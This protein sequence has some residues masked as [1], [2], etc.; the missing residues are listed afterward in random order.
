MVLFILFTPYGYDKDIWYHDK[1]NNETDFVERLKKYGNI[2]IDVPIF[3]KYLQS[4]NDGEY[5]FT[6]DDIKFENYSMNLYKKVSDL[7]DSFILIGLEESC[8]YALYFTNK[9]SSQ[10]VGL[11]II[12]NRRFTKENYLKS[13]DRSHKMIGKYFGEGYEKYID[14]IND[15]NLEY[16]L[17]KI[18]A[19]NN[20]KYLAM[21]SY[22]VMNTLRSQYDDLPQRCSVPTFIY[23]RVTLSRDVMLEHNPKTEDVKYIKNI[24]SEPEAIMVHCTINMDKYTDS[25]KLIGNSPK[26]LVKAYYIANEDFNLF[27]YGDT[28]DDI[29]E[30]IEIFV[31]KY[32]EQDGRDFNKTNSNEKILKIG[33]RTY[34]YKY[35]KYK[36]KYL[37]IKDV[38]K[39]LIQPFKGVEIT[40]D[41]LNL[42]PVVS[43]TNKLMTFD[44]PEVS[45]S[46]VQY[47]EGSTGCTYIRFNNDRTIF[48][49][50]R[51]GGYV[52]TASSDRVRLYKNNIRGICFSGGSFLGLEAISGC[53]AEE[54]KAINYTN[55]RNCYIVGATLRS[56]NLD[57][58]RIYPDK[59]LGRFAVNNLKQNQI[60]LGQAGAGCMAGNGFYGQGASFKI[61]QGIKIFVVSAVN[62]LG[63]IHNE[64]GQVLRNRWQLYDKNK[65]N[66]LDEIYGKNSTLT[67]VITDLS[68]DLFELEQLSIQCH[69]NMAVVIRPFNMI[70]DGDVLFGVSLNNIDKGNIH[71]FD[72]KDFYRICSEVTNDAVLNCFS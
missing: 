30:K 22:Y 57:Y 64:K 18:D 29:L 31:N 58:N 4:D 27:I 63:V 50:D 5:K 11:F 25:Q 70:G 8:H 38:S 13:V 41:N 3:S 21:I 53:V 44:F 45:I 59:N 56:A 62:A 2:F 48:Y 40:N 6:L 43:K 71:N 34:Y 37:S 23:N 26:G 47:K 68:L 52:T 19:S 20:I 15:D 14:N 46:S 7:D 42:V 65:T 51:R 9:Y 49:C 35:I 54:L 55:F 16:L 28:K 39:N 24:Y 32:I 36:T 60:Y 69:T 17:N 67:T 61:Y 12:G 1:K 72:I 66:D 33:L 10:C